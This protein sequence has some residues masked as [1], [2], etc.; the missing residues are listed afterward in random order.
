MVDLL[1]TSAGLIATVDAD[2]REIASGWLAI[3]DGFISRIGT[4]S[5]ALLMP[6][7]PWTS[8]G[9]LLLLGW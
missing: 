1:L 2:R 4:A 6:T 3:T 9:R 5:C 7:R 8:P